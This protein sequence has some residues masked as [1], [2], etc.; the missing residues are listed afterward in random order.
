MRAIFNIN[1]ITRWGENLILVDDRDGT[2][3]PMTYNDGFFWSCML[4]VGPDF[5][6][7]YQ[8]EGGET[9]RIETLPHSL[10]F[11]KP[12]LQ[13]ATFLDSWQEPQVADV[14]G[15]APFKTLFPR[16]KGRQACDNVA[17]G[18]ITLRVKAPLVPPEYVLAI[19]GNTPQLGNWDPQKGL[20][21]APS[22]FP[23]FS[24]CMKPEPYM[25]FKFVVLDADSGELIA[26]EN[27]DNHEL[28]MLFPHNS[29]LVVT[30]LSF[31]SPLSQWRCA[32]TAVPL[33]SL[34]SSSDMGVGDFADI[35][36]LVDWASRTG[37]HIL[38][39]LPLNDTTSCDSY[40]N[41]FPYNPV[42]GFA[43]H[44]VYIRPS[45]VGTL[46]D[47]R[48]MA[49]FTRRAM[50]LNSLKS[51][52]YNAV[53]HL[54]IDYMRAIYSE[55]HQAIHQDEK[56]GKFVKNN[57]FWLRPYAAYCI[58]R[59]QLETEHFDRWGLYSK[60]D[61]QKISAFLE[62]HSSEAEFIYFYQYH[63]HEQ[64]SEAVKHA[65]AR[66]VLLKGDLPIGMSRYCVEVWQHPEYF[67]LEHQAG[68]Q[69]DYLSTGGQA[70]GF[71]L[72]NWKTMEADGYSWLK[73]RLR[74]MAQYFDCYR[75]DHIMGYMRMWAIEAGPRGSKRG[76]Y[77]PEIPDV[78]LEINELLWQQLGT[79]HLTAIVGAT[80][81]LP[82]G[83]NVGAAPAALDAVMKKLGIL[84]LEIMQMPKFEYKFRWPDTFPYM[85]VCATSNHDMPVIRSWWK[86]DPEATQQFYELVLHHSNKAPAEA[87]P[88]V[89]E[90]ILA[91]NLN[92]K[93]MLAI[94]P[95]QD[96]LSIDEGLRNSDPESE[97]VND[98]ASMQPH[99][100]YR[101][102]ISLETVVAASSFNK[103]ISML[104]AQS[105]R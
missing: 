83:E 92:A 41:S 98:P 65:H 78:S 71:P 53:L 14:S 90:E 69:P 81:M 86:Q 67:D 103:K 7:H 100:D 16:K 64:L 2:R 27:G 63:L 3:H 6:Y 30:G 76:R 89:C 84:S 21:M 62:A 72:Y 9:A 82:C 95:I 102:H 60:Y 97:R 15:T 5:C 73:A 49:R 68:A 57:A 66:K 55:N 58:L 80:A 23:Y 47:K 10:S 51:I 44:P 101:M 87:T 70:W 32:G 43:L 31:S 54:K 105:G 77:L 17:P 39:F 8:V 91:V 45:L 48:L 61:E 46:A 37:Q 19:V 28:T 35:P 79:R 33:F 34:R 75:I 104:I 13:E 96:W 12:D 40:H 59:N 18:H 1:Y 29:A 38:Q 26:W 36:K 50:H 11:C 4:D 74:H 99:W 42:S 56:L 93:S 52:D 88:D 24:I 22:T 25:E 85:S 94:F 20:K